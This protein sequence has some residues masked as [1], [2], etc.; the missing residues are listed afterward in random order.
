[1][2]VTFV[3]LLTLALIAPIQHPETLSLLEEPLYPPPV[4]KAERAR[5][6]EEIARARADLARDPADQDA[7]LRLARAQRGL[8]HIGDALE[9]L[10]RAIEAKTDAPALRLERGRGFIA[11]RKFDLA[12]REFRKAAEALPEARCG[13]AFALYLLADYKQS[14]E[15][16]GRCAEPGMFGYLAARRSGAPAGSRPAPP[17]ADADR[18]SADIRLPGSVAPKP[19]A[20]APSIAVSYMDAVDRLLADQKPAAKDLL[21]QIVEKNRKLWMEPLYVAAENDYARIVKTEPKK[22]K[23]K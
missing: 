21:K 9:T 17:P 3:L 18:R 12:E 1:M 13:V 10:T 20:D 14:T 4:S 2:V 11:I 22:K 16:Y 23:R 5:L 7:T 6:E 15:E 19:K 8:G